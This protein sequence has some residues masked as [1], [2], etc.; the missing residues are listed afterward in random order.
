[1]PARKRQLVLPI[2]VITLWT[3]G[4]NVPLR[5]GP[6]GTIGVQRERAVLHD[7]FPS[8]ELGP[9]IVG[10]RPLG[11]DTPLA[12]PASIQASP[13]ANRSRRGG[14]FQPTYGF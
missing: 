14:L 6:P 12:E 3:S 10:G 13:W 2:V 4:C 1:M 8:N 5:Q 9:P 11:F 7:P